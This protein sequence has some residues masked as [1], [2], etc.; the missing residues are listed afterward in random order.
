[1]HELLRS[2]QPMH[3]TCQEGAPVGFDTRCPLEL[4]HDILA[5]HLVEIQGLG[6]GDS[7]DS[8]SSNLGGSRLQSKFVSHL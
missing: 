4:S 6:L 3:L 1:M 7:K 8:D 2:H 5:S